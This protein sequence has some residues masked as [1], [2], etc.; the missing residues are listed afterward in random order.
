VLVPPA[1]ELAAS[2]ADTD[3]GD[4]HI[5]AA[6]ASAGAWVIVTPD[7][8]DFGRADLARLGVSAVNPDLFLAHMMTEAMYRFTL[9]R[10]AH[11]RTLEPNTPATIH[12]SL[13]RVHP[14]LAAAMRA[15]FPRV[16]PL[17]SAD[18]APAEVFRG[19]RCL[20]CGRPLST[21]Q[22]L[23]CGVGPECTR[24]GGFPQPTS[25]VE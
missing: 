12:A 2:L 15:A 3:H 6:A 17:P 24:P 10:L 5:L 13:G 22:S 9:E 8:D 25:A 16:E 18:A 21:P 14:R 20:A 1:P 11:A 19:D 4:R 23:A 7:V